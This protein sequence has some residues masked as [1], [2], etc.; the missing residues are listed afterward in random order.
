MTADTDDMTDLEKCTR[1]AHRLLLTNH[2]N[3]TNLEYE[4]GY[5]G[6]TAIRIRPRNGEM[7]YIPYIELWKGD[8]LYAEFPQ[9]KC[10][11]VYFVARENPDDIA[12]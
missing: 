7:A 11:G 2:E 5:G 9:H 12:F 6:I 10:A 3:V 4:V 1:D 8:V